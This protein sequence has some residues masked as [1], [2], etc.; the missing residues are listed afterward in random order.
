MDGWYRDVIA[1]KKK[2]IEIF[3]EPHPEESEE[4]LE[5]FPKLWEEIREE[6]E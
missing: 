2:L 5:R 6:R 1:S 4:G 3:Q